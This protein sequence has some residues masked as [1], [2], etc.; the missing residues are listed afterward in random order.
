M[1]HSGEC[2]GTRPRSEI[3][4]NLTS[5]Q[6]HL[7]LCIEDTR[8]LSCQSSPCSG[9]GCG[10]NSGYALLSRLASVE[11]LPRARVDVLK[12]IDEDGPD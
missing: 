8:A 9:P 11:R 4:L 6:T 10:G 5:M 1:R 12:P 2:P 3:L 7:H